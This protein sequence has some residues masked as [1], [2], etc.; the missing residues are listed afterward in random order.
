[1]WVVIHGFVCLEDDCFVGTLFSIVAW[2][3]CLKIDQA[4]SI[5]MVLVSMSVSRSFRSARMP[6]M[7]DFFQRVIFRLRG[8]GLLAVI[9][10]SVSTMS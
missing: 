8:L 7:S 4:S 10:V 9:E 5:D 1:M 2:I 3:F 6:S